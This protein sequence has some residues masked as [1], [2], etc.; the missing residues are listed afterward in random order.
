MSAKGKKSPGTRPTLLSTPVRK[1]PPVKPQ[2]LD[3]AEQAKIAR[4]LGVSTTTLQ[5]SKLSTSVLKS[6]AELVKWGPSEIDKF[7]EQITKDV[8]TENK[9]EL[10][11]VLKK[12]AFFDSIHDFWPERVTKGSTDED[13]DEPEELDAT[14]LET[15]HKTLEASIRAYTGNMSS[16]PLSTILQTQTNYTVSSTSDIEDKVLAY[17]KKTYAP[18]NEPEMYITL[19]EI[20]SK[21]K[22]TDFGSNWQAYSTKIRQLPNALD[23]VFDGRNVKSL[24]D[25]ERNHLGFF[26]L[27]FMNP[28]V[29]PG[30]ADVGFTFDMSPKDIGKIFARFTQVYNAVYPQNIAD[31]APTSFSALLG[32]ARFFHANGALAGTLPP[33]SVPP[34]LIRSN[35]FTWNK[36]K[37]EFIDN[38]FGPANKFGFSIRVTDRS[39]GVSRDIP[40]GGGTEQGPSVNYLMDVISSGTTTGVEPKLSTAAKLTPIGPSPDPDLLFDIKR[41]GDQEQMLTYGLGITGD[42]FAAAFRRLLRKSGMFHSTRGIK[43]WRGYGALTEAQMAEQTRQFRTF[44]VIEKLKIITGVLGSGPGSLSGIATQLQN[45]RAHVNSGAEHG[46]VFGATTPLRGKLTRENVESKYTQIASTFATYVLRYRM[47]DI[48]QQI[49]SLLTKINAIRSQIPSVVAS[50]CKLDQPSP[51]P[52]QPCPPGPT[53]QTIDGALSVLE[54]FTDSIEELKA[55]NISLA[56]ELNTSSGKVVSTKEPINPVLFDSATGRLLKGA[57]SFLFNFSAGPYLHP[58][59]GLVTVVARLLVLSKSKRPG[60]IASQINKLLV[61]YF[62][63]RD[64]AKE[65]FF[66][67]DAKKNIERATDITSGLSP[68]RIVAIGS[69]PGSGQGLLEAIESMAVLIGEPASGGGDLETIP[70]VVGGGEQTGGVR[71]AANALQYRDI[72]DLF[73]ELCFDAE[74]AIETKANTFSALDDIETR[75]ITSIDELRTHSVDDYTVPFDESFETD[76]VSYILSFRS[77]SSGPTYATLFNEKDGKLYPGWE[78]RLNSN[79]AMLNTAR[80]YLIE[81]SSPGM[82]ADALVLRALAVFA[83]KFRTNPRLF[84]AW[85]TDGGEGQWSGIPTAFNQALMTV[86]PLPAQGA[87]SAPSSN[88]MDFSANGGGLE[89]SEQATSNAG[90]SSSS[91]PSGGR[92]GLYARL[93][94]RSGS[95]SPPGLRE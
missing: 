12:L 1:H 45:M 34:Y 85:G 75:W 67:P 38:G 81:Y 23:I 72:H 82:R 51:D 58:E 59:S 93:R 42:R 89:T 57:K 8:Q 31:S 91:V 41:M 69:S 46:V 79:L 95:G 30:S 60:T 28:Q 84:E 74:L 40:F 87:P 56:A 73:V 16:V 32:R 76:Y 48:R 50:A 55:M 20:L 92:R 6:A 15:V 64:A 4:D 65:A 35:A 94:K 29:N 52:S 88:A 44:Q 53:L 70:A 62:Q 11:A 78:G 14:R 39:N 26:L 43:A 66:S 90:G 17:F 27:A 68:E 25:T 54:K 19:T 5:K 86:N 7:W 37:L 47:M 61:Q 33:G 49:D 18:F 24:S 77:T 36:Y 21:W 83:G 63:A 80:R 2:R 13:E 22:F 71:T 3:P 10:K 9:T